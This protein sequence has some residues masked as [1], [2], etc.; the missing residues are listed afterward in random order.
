MYTDFTNLNKT[1][2]KDF[3][4]LPSLGRSVDGSAGHEVFDF[5]DASRGYHQIRI[6]PEDEESTTF[7]TEYDLYC[8]RVMPFGLKNAGAT[9]QLLNHR[10][11]EIWRYMWMICW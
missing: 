7:I 9:Y 1:C 2:P 4:R 6:L 11:G 5:M 8:W 10:L 3:Y